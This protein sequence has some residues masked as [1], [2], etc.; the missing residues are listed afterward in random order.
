MFFPAN[1]PPAHSVHYSSFKLNSLFLNYLR[2]FLLLCSCICFPFYLE[3]LSP[4]FTLSPVPRELLLNLEYPD[5]TLSLL[6]DHPKPL[7]KENILTSPGIPRFSGPLLSP[8]PCN[9]E[10]SVFTCL[11]CPVQPCIYNVQDTAN[12]IMGDQQMTFKWVS[13][14]IPNGL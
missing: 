1:P 9:H 7:Q 14:F 2:F 11:G 8:L 3:C 12:H 4:L 6:W 13:R 10:S 5:K